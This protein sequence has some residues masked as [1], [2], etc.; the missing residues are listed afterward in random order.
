[1]GGGL[2]EISPWL[3]HRGCLKSLCPSSRSE[4]FLDVAGQL[5]DRLKIFVGQE[6]KLPDKNNKTLLC[7][8][9]CLGFH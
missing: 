1:M 4:I 5:S 6:R 9:F 7:L 8:E 2:G 3:S